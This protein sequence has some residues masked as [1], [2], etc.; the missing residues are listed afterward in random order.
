MQDNREFFVCLYGNGNQPVKVETNWVGGTPRGRPLKYVSHLIGAV[1]AL[2]NSP[3]A[4]VFVGDITLH[5]QGE[6]GVVCDAL[7]SRTLLSSLQG[8]SLIIKAKGH[9]GKCLVR[10]H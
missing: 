8:D 1:K 7:S 3:L 4:N 5:E 6:G 2:P 9:G 10:R